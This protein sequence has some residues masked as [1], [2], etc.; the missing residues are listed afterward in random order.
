M[1]NSISGTITFKNTN[2]LYIEN[3]GIEWDFFVPGL[4]LDAFGALG[5]ETKVYTWLYHREDAMRLF[6]FSSVRERDLF[7]DLMKVEGIGPKQ[8]IKILSSIPVKDLETA[9]DSEDLGRLE[10]APGIGKKTAQKMI[11]ALKGKLTHIDDASSKRSQDKKS[12]HEDIVVALANMGFERKTAIVAVEDAVR[13][14][15]ASADFAESGP[16]S[17]KALEQEIFRRA[18]VALSSK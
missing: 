15:K 1:F 7:I 2:S 5:S 6:G 9:L 14:L 12:E 18:I 16:G 3:S 10:S 4:S 11:L 17:G 8:A 13:D